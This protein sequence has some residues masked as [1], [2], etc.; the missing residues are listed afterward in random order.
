MELKWQIIIF[1]SSQVCCA[2][3]IT[4]KV[5]LRMRS[6]KVLSRSSYL[7]I[8]IAFFPSSSNAVEKCSI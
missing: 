7:L 1:I 8:F 5:L 3:A 2:H 6:A 4:V